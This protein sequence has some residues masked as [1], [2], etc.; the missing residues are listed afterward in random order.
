[1][2]TLLRVILTVVTAALGLFAL[3]AI[4]PWAPPAQV[5]VVGA[6]GVFVL[7]LLIAAAGV[8]I[9]GTPAAYPAA[10]RRPWLFVALGSVALIATS[11]LWL[12]VQR[13]GA[14]ATPGLS[15]VDV[16]ALLV[17]PLFFGALLALPYTPMKREQRWV[18]AV[19]V[20]IVVLIGAISLWQVV[21]PGL[22][23]TPHT[24]L[25]LALKLAYPL[26]DL[27]IL[28]GLVTLAQ[29]EV[30]LIDRRV[31][32][33]LAGGLLLL[34]LTDTGRA[35]VR[36]D[37]L[38]A[39]ALLYLGWLAGLWAVLLAAGWQM[40]QSRFEAQSAS[41]FAPL[42]HTNLIYAVVLIIIAFAIVGVASVLGQNVMLAIT[43]TGSRL[44]TLL[45]VLRQFFVLRENRQL[46]KALEKLAVTDGLTGLANRRLFD[47]ALA[48][49]IIRA[50]RYQRPLS[51]LMMDVNDFKRL[52]DERGH[53]AGDEVLRTLASLIRAQLR[54]SDFAARY[55]GDEFVVILPESDAAMARNVAEKLEAAIEAILGQD[56]GPMVSIGRAAF[57]PKM[58]SAALLELADQ[59]MYRNKAAQTPAPAPPTLDPVSVSD[60]SG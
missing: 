46:T 27:L 30:P 53:V 3:W 42:L 31:L 21:A 36:P 34:V 23:A 32:L 18:L 5:M 29:R 8:Y 35:G 12:I 37:D 24:G 56:H 47:E 33:A 60:P 16:A 19:D 59:D 41:S 17:Y 49:E 20:S 28:A 7:A 22:L 11:A 44:L 54:A 43:L 38:R 1:M 48:R 14:E 15:V 50:Q 10:V 55:G 26:G 2:R 45:V 4:S 9:A 40:R 13:P 52:N 51:L 39:G 58:T 6:A 25:E 57:Q